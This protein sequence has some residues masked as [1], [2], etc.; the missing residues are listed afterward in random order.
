MATIS[1][2][3][4]AVNHNAPTDA[5]AINMYGTGTASFLSLGQLV[6]AVC[7]RAAAVFESQSVV[8]MN[9]M[10]SG[11]ILLDTAAGWLSKIVDENSGCDWT[12]A[13]NFLVNS[14]GIDASTLP[15]N[16]LSYN[17]RMQAAQ[18]LKEKMETLTTN[19]QTEMIDL[20][21]LVN[22]RDVAYSTSTNAT[23]TLATSL[24]SN[25]AN[26]C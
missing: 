25:A 7:I 11:S 12:E 18:A 4:I 22:R 6:Q 26:F 20:Q 13:K 3:E 19:Q 5:A 17:N 16:L 24:S 8:K 9:K 14:M 2:T 1:V 21:T 15:P 10:T 23:R